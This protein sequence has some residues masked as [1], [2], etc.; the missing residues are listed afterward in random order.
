MQ[1]IDTHAHLYQ[2]E[3]ENDLDNILLNCKNNGIEQILIPN[4]DAES[5]PLMLDLHNKYPKQIKMML[6]IHP[7]YVQE[8]Y[9]EL[10]SQMISDFDAQK[11]VAIGE[12]GI[13]LY[14]DKSTLQIQQD[15]FVD[16]IKWAKKVN[17][18]IVI[19]ARESF[20]EI[21]EI[22]DQEINENLRGVFHCF[23]GGEIERDKILTYP[24]FYFG[25]GGVVTYKNSN[26]PTVLPTIPNELL[27]LETDAPY[28]SPVPHR[29]KRNEPNHLIHTAQ[30]LAEIKKLTLQEIAQITTQNAHK[31]FSL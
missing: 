13:D 7:C 8:N 15:A 22:I 25:I 3:F 21:F 17:L 23:T 11:Y 30:K 10:L 19:H 16:Q 5:W 26:L 1:F 6:G 14:W 20:N 24:N 28:L 12:I 9:G 29:G 31:L 2:T 4:V 27:L 18:P